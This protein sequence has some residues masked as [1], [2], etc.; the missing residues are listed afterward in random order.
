MQFLAQTLFN[1][2]KKTTSFSQLIGMDTITMNP[3]STLTTVST[4]PPSGSTIPNAEF[5][6]DGQPAGEDGKLAWGELERDGQSTGENN[7]GKS[8]WGELERDGQ[9]AGKDGKSAW[10]EPERDGQSTGEKLGRDGQ[11][12]GEDG[13][14]AWGEPKRDSL[15]GEKLGRDGQFTGGDLV[16][17][18]FGKLSRLERS[19]SSFSLPSSEISLTAEISGPIGMT[20]E[21]VPRLGA[22]VGNNGNVKE[23]S[24]SMEPDR[25]K[26]TNSAISSVCLENK[27]LKNEKVNNEK[28]TGKKNCS[29]SK[30]IFT[31]KH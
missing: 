24:N 18:E 6:R 27:I 23:S 3:S 14:P 10:G 15:T 19:K 12:A 2:P 29:Q 21:L 7:G 4:T 25:L 30:S 26:L 20:M 17:D 9:S 16:R 11:S 28:L 8:D 31:A 1:Y 5:G 13:K 22:E